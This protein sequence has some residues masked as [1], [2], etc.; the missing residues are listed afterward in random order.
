MMARR[1][2]TSISARLLREAHCHGIKRKEIED[3]LRIMP[4]VSPLPSYAFPL[5]D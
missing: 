4:F 2:P 3:T 1:K 5:L